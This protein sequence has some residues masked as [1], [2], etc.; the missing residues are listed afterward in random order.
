MSDITLPRLGSGKFEVGYVETMVEDGKNDDT[1]I[2][3][4]IY[5]PADSTLTCEESEHP[6]W[7]AREEYLDG[8]AEYRNSSAELLHL[9]YNWFIGSK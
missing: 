3:L 6:L 7:L 1:N 5:Y 8:L 4:T 2:L 9:V